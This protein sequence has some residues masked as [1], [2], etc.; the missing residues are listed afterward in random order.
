MYRIL[1]TAII[2]CVTL[3]IGCMRDNESPD[4][5][6]TN[7]ANGSVV[8]GTVNITAE[9]TDNKGVEKVEFYIDGVIVSTSTSRPYTYSWSTTSLQDSSSHTIYAKAFDAADNE[10]ISQTVSVIVNNG[11]G[12][13]GGGL[14]WSDGFE[15]YSIGSWPLPYWINS[16]NDSGYVDNS[17]YHSGSQSFKLYGVIGSFWAAHAN[18]AIGTT[19]PWSVE[20]Y[21]KTGSEDIPPDGHQVRA[22]LQ[23]HVQPDWTSDGR[24]LVNFHKDGNIYSSGNQTLGTYQTETWY[25]VKIKYEYPVSGQVRCIYWI[26]DNQVGQ[27][28][29]TPVSNENNLAYITLIAQAGTV[30]YD[31][32]SMSH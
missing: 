10:G 22:T 32:V 27:E 16:G 1:I 11:S 25:K 7:P 15:T 19:A 29:L 31:D 28:T 18:H 30:W 24:I 2:L 6:I 26:N 14:L 23:L 5:Q 8:S 21:I 12:G 17:V 13:G 3:W 9:A 4:V 20:C